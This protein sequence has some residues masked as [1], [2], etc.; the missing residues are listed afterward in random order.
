VHDYVF[1]VAIFVAVLAFQAA[2][3]VA[4]L[5]FGVLRFSIAAVPLQAVAIAVFTSPR[6]RFGR[7]RW[8]APVGAIAAVAVLL[9]AFPAAARTML[10]RRLAP[11]EASVLRAGFFPQRASEADRNFAERPASWRRIARAID[12]RHLP[13]G[14][15]ATDAAYASGVILGS[16]RP[17]QFVTTPD[18]DFQ[19]I[20]AG[21]RFFP[22]VRY[23]LL[24]DPK[25]YPND[26][27]NRQHPRLYTDGIWDGGRATL[28]EEFDL[29]GGVWRLYRL[30]KTTR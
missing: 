17:K 7:T 5:T 27:L 30:T 16:T 18:R 10:D 22:R 21:F 23:A 15:V 26:E 20:V 13:N 14:S 12:D 4:G 8:A 28:E 6:G 29:A 2:G 19:Q 11:E 1:P 9:P 24:Q 3:F 25:L